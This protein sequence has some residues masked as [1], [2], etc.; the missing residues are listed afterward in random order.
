MI[1][2]LDAC[3]IT[4]DHGLNLNKWYFLYISLVDE[5]KTHE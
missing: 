1:C 5:R 2:S 4:S 3:S